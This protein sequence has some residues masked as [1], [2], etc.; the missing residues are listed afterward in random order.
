MIDPKELAT[1]IEH[2]Q[3]SIPFSTEE[4]NFVVNRLRDDVPLPPE[5]TYGMLMAL[6]GD[7]VLLAASDEE[8]LK[9]RYA[10]MIRNMGRDNSPLPSGD[11]NG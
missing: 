2:G 10:N 6:A 4:L 5:P 7:P 11:K 1:R 3:F 9:I 8:E